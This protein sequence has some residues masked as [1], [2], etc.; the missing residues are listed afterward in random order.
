MPFRHVLMAINEY[1]FV[2]SDYPVILSIE[3]H[4]CTAVQK[5][6]AE[7]FENIF[8]GIIFCKSK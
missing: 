7:E 8:G 6:M 5:K 4:C 3:D 1:A 2:K